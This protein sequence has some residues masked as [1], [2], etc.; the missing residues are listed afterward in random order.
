ME[1][2]YQS[3]IGSG[4]LKTSEIKIEGVNSLE[5]ISDVLNL[6]E[7]KELTLNDVSIDYEFV[8]GKTIS[9]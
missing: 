3:M 1:P 8:D 2:I 5:Q 4:N 9:K 6:K 7:L